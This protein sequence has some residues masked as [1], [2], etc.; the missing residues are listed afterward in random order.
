MWYS[1]ALH[2]M[3]FAEQLKG[4]MRVAIIDASEAKP[5]GNWV[6]HRE[7]RRQG[8][9]WRDAIVVVWTCSFLCRKERAENVGVSKRCFLFVSQATPKEVIGRN[10]LA[11]LDC[12]ESWIHI[13]LNSI[14]KV[15][16]WPFCK[17]RR[18]CNLQFSNLDH[19][20]ER[21]KIK[22]HLN[23]RKWP[24]IWLNNWHN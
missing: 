24:S 16:I 3:I 22:S 18:K 15:F 8:R 12:K 4:F 20:F 6:S 14:D 23:G 2:V 10:A 17:H 1:E 19:I 5:A 7:R 11:Y 9:W 13:L 21:G